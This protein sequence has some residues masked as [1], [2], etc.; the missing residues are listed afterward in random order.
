MTDPTPVIP[1]PGQPRDAPLAPIDR[2]GPLRQAVNRHI[3]TLQ[4]GYFDDHAHAVQALARLRRGVGRQP[5]ET[6]ELWGLIGVEAFHSAYLAQHR[7]P[8]GEAEMLRAEHAAH[9]AVTLWAVH[10]QSN[11]SRRMHVTDGPSVGTAVRRLMSGTDADDP[12]R[13]RLVRAGTAS[14]LDVLAQRLRDLVTLMRSAE[15]PLDY[16]L[17]AEQLD[18]WQR[19]GGPG[20]V[21]QAWGR[22][23]HAYRPPSPR[24]TKDQDVSAVQLEIATNEMRENE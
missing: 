8:A 3:G 15:V 13:N 9:V 14:T 24:T 20:Q 5:T 2:F 7:R 12:I 19:P 4:S 18:Q 22:S 23:F 16:G 10:Q 21:R 1:A 6:P 11:R 17:L